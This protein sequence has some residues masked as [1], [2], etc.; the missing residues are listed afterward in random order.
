MTTLKNQITSL[1]TH[2]VTKRLLIAVPLAVCI[3]L[4]RSLI[5]FE[6]SALIGFING[7][8]AYFVADYVLLSN[9]GRKKMLNK[10][11]DYIKDN[12]VEVVKYSMLLAVIIFFFGAHEK[13]PD[14][15]IS[16]IQRMVEIF[17]LFVVLMYPIFTS[18]FR[19]IVNGN[20]H[21][22]MMFYIG[23]VITGI[24]VYSVVLWMIGLYGVTTK[25]WIV[26]NPNEAAVAAVSFILVWLILK[27]SYGTHYSYAENIAR[28]G[29]AKSAMLGVRLKPKRTDRDNK[30][31]AA[32]E[33]GH[34]LVYAALGCLPPGIEVV[35]R[36]ESSMDDSLGY[37]S[38]INSDHQLNDKKFSEWLMLV[39]LAGKYGE[40]F[41]FGENTM[42][43]TNDHQH[44]LNIARTYLSN[45]FDGIYY[46]D[47]QSKF[48][49]ELN[50]EKLENLQKKQNAMLESLFTKNANTFNCI[51]DELLAKKRMGRSDLI[52][53]L[54]QVILPD[55][56]P[57]PLGKFTE[58]SSEWPS[59]LGFYTDND[60][61]TES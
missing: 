7:I 17:G 14:P 3:G 29:S 46:T 52:P 26:T 34:A 18:F 9:E 33:S 32:H 43:S 55:G 38:G 44:W 27:F 56:F 39:F 13:S 21:S 49:Q 47:P 5:G 6:Q 36:D 57:L 50:E 1:I 23:R 25:E 59:N 2:S 35:I 30:Y 19:T 12:L 41:A 28:G 20:Y 51:C 4:L 48:E 22:S 15:I 24:A 16:Q 61:K 45:H 37:V 53:H 54:C 11:I 60:R 58:F 8:A 42:G 10:G 40:S 31:T